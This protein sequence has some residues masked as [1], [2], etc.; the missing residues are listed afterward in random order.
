MTRASQAMMATA[1]LFLV[2]VLALVVVVGVM[3]NRLND[4]LSEIADA[5][6]PSAVSAAV[7][8]IQAST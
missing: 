4:T 1:L 5:V 2:L 8:G 7:Q 6:G 3:M